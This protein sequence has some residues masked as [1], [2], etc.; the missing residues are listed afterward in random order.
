M[1]LMV[2]IVAVLLLGAAADARADEK[3][4]L[5]E[6][7]RGTWASFVAMTDER[8]GLPA[9]ILE[10]DGTRSVQTS[11]TNIGAYMWSAVA[12]ERLGLIGKHELVARLSRTVATLERMERYADTGQYYNWYDHRTGAKLT[13]WPPDPDGEFHPILSS[14][15]NG[16]LAVGLRIVENSVP[17][18]RRRAGA[19]YDAM[20]WG[21]YYRPEVNRVLFHF[22]PDDPA[23][24]PCC[25]D[26]LVSE[27]RI[28]DYLGIAR[29]QLPQKAY[30][31][32]WRTFPDSCDW[33][34]QET[35]PVGTWRR[36]FGVDVFEGAYPCRRSAGRRR[37]GVRTTR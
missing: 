3:R 24:S 7:A 29:G 23:A 13:V 31:G 32:R 30:Y 36:Y 26:T 6:Y 9:D 37:A 33:S 14:V 35:R 18:L 28:V 16:W 20:N 17:Q 15:D 22:R 1:K 11:T 27:S 19:L 5:R 25:Y 8:S 12:A 2:T 4:Q 34:W 21:F 10:A